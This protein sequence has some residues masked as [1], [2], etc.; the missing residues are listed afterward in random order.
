MKIG[1]RQRERK[2]VGILLN[3]EELKRNA[4]KRWLNHSY[5]A[6][7]PGPCLPLANYLVSLSTLD[8]P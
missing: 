5:K 7:L 8:L 3:E 4:V 2:G 6:V 1:A